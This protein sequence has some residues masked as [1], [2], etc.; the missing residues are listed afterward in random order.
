MEG[1]R[2]KADER[3]MGGY[4]QRDGRGTECEVQASGEG[5]QGKGR[6]RSRGFIWSD[7]AIVIEEG[8]IVEG[9][10]HEAKGRCLEETH[11]CGC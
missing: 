11:A 4:E 3:E 1:Q 2:E 9:G 7:T 8:I 6:Q 10:N 5:F